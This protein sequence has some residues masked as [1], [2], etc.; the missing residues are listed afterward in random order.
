M[1]PVLLMVCAGVIGAI[2]GPVRPGALPVQARHEQPVTRTVAQVAN[3]FDYEVIKRYAV[4]ETKLS[5][6]IRISRRVSSETLEGI[7]RKLYES[8]HGH[9]YPKVYLTFYLPGM[10]VDAEVWATAF[11]DPTLKVKVHGTT[12][13]SVATLSKPLPDDGRKLVG[14]WLS[15][16]GFLGL[17]FTIYRKGKLVFMDIQHEDGSVSTLQ[18]L[19]RRQSGQQRFVVKESIH[20]GE[21]WFINKQGDLGLF[22]EGLTPRTF[23]QLRR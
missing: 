15:N 18:L 21:Y 11:F 2:V 13:E 4:P 19:E 5:L 23:P 17:S 7:A 3:D 9:S 14:Q 1:L 10:E 16:S 20:P 12:D 6:D 22:T 8:E